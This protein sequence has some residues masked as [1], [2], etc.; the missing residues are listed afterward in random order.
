MGIAFY[1]SLRALVLFTS[2]YKYLC[3]CLT[4]SS[5]SVSCPCL[6]SNSPNLYSTESRPE[7]VFNRLWWKLTVWRDTCSCKVPACSQKD[8]ETA[9][10]GGRK[11]FLEVFYE[12]ILSETREYGAGE[13]GECVPIDGAAKS[14]KPLLSQK[15]FSAILLQGQCCF[16]CSP[17][18]SC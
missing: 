1:P 11:C 8:G 17:L 14:E 9:G 2:C 18:L 7:K 12:S 5:V 3:A 16:L 4:I 10:M 15:A 13:S 6:T